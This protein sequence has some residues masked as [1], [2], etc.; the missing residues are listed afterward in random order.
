MHYIAKA[1]A[2]LAI[3]SP[4]MAVFTAEATLY[5]DPT[6]RQL[7][8]FVNE[9]KRYSSDVSVT[10]S[11][12]KTANAKSLFKLDNLSLDAGT[13]ITIKGEGDDEQ[14][15]VENLVRVAREF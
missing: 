1:L 3:A 13:I 15:A 8:V 6:T 5:A 9:A 7:S 4:A 12:G 14:E 11:A 10:D 2:C